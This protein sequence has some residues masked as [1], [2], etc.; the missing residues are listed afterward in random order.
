MENLDKAL[1]DLV[2][3]LT[4]SE[5]FMKMTEGFADLE[6]NEQ[7]MACLLLLNWWLNEYSKETADETID[8]IANALRGAR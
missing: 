3:K 1:Q 7:M 2:E 5:P 4:S 6:R 8:I